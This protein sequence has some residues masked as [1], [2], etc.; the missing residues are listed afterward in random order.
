MIFCI[1]RNEHGYFIGTSDN[2]DHRVTPYMENKPQLDCLLP[3][4]LPL[5]HEKYLESLFLNGFFEW[6]NSKEIEDFITL[7]NDEYCYVA[8]LKKEFQNLNLTNN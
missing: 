4:L 2:G 1:R 8:I 6:V 5:Q 7:Y 3:L